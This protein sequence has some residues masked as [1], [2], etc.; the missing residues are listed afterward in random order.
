MTVA[1]RSGLG[2]PGRGVFVTGASSGIGA[3]VAVEWARAG[4]VVAGASR[5]G[6]VPPGEGKLAPVRLDVND[7]AAMATAI[8]EFATASGGLAGV[9]HCAGY[10]EF[11]PSSDLSMD[12]LRAVLETNLVSA[13]RIAQLARPHLAGPGGFVA[14]IGSFY[15]DLGVPGSLAYSASKAALASVTRTLAVEWAA[16][17]VALVNFA[18]GYVET[19]LNEEYLADPENRARLERRIPVGRVGTADEI[20]RLVVAVLTADCQFLTGETI[21]IDG[22]QG[23]RL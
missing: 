5:R 11:S 6:T 15:A 3:A 4:Y 19:G 22:A 2:A 8:D 13:V 20:A 21:T 14:F 12:D 16:D 17:G 9:V 7:H 23:R 10:Q 18:P 1:D